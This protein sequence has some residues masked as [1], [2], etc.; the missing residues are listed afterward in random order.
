MFMTMLHLAPQL[1]IYMKGLY[2]DEATGWGFDF[3]L[4]YKTPIE[5][6]SAAMVIRNLG[7]MNV[8]KNESTVCRLNSG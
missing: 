5:G 2:S 7:H 8:L 4:N 1:N 6:L 3:G